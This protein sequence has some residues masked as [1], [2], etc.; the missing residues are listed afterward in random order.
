MIPRTGARDEVHHAYRLV[1][2]FISGE[3]G[4]MKHDCSRCQAILTEHIPTVACGN[5]C[6]ECGRYAY[7]ADQASYLYLLTNQKLQ[8][9]KVGIGTVGKDKN[10]LQELIG[11]GWNA[12]GIW[13]SADKQETFKWEKE[14]F[15]GLKIKFEFTGQESIGFVG[16]SDKHWFESVSAE[17]ISVTDLAHIISKIVADKN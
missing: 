13:H 12:C 14:V 16:N 1:A 4:D 3:G 9:H 6:N 15:K 17:A 7:R 11:S 10:Y 5:T 2:T 8:L